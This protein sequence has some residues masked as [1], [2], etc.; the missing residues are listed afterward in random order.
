MGRRKAGETPAQ[1][2]ARLERETGEDKGEPGRQRPNGRLDFSVP[3]SNAGHFFV[4]PLPCRC[5]HPFS[6][7]PCRS[8]HTNCFHTS[9]IT[10]NTCTPQTCARVINIGVHRPHPLAYT[11]QLRLAPNDDD[12][13][14]SI[15]NCHSMDAST[16]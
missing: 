4:L 10:H 12:H 9:Y 6:R 3:E 1:R 8:L 5:R 13:L 16:P 15:F 11:T 14:S 2:S 7:T